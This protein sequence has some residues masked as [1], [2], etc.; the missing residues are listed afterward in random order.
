MDAKENGSKIL[1]AL[2]VLLSLA[3]CGAPMENRSVGIEQPT[4]LIIVGFDLVGATLLIDESRLTLSSEMKKPF[5]LGIAG[6]KDTDRQKQDIFYIPLDP[7]KHSLAI[8]KPGKVLLRKDI[9]LS[10]GQSR[11]VLVQ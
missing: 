3:G 7:G 6:S 8:E 5:R 4:Q 2:F 9:Y 10:E 11:E 1:S